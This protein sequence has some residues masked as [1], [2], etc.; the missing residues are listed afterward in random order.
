MILLIIGLILT[1]L[2]NLAV[3]YLI[4]SYEKNNCEQCSNILPIKKQILKIY[5][6]ITFVLI[7]IVY[8]LPFCLIILRLKSIGIGLSN[9]IKSTTGNLILT[10]YLILGFV[11][12]YLLFRYTKQLE[13]IECN[14]ENQIQEKLRKGL[15]FYSMIVLIIYIITSIITFAIK[16][17]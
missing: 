8:I 11:N 12:I 2:V 15:N 4:K 14:C 9:I 3:L 6:L 16:F 13:Y 5:A 1:I 7:F 17:N 10:L